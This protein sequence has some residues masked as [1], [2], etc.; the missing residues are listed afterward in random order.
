MKLIKLSLV[1]LLIGATGVGDAWA[2]RGHGHRHGHGV[3]FGFVAGPFWGPWYGSRHYP[4]V[5]IE[6]VSPPV[7]IER[8]SD[9]GSA[10][11][12]YYCA[13]AKGYYPYVKQCPGGWQQVAPRPEDQ[14]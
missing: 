11:F 14:P 8:S 10:N 7:Y 12:W 1:L 9:S 2:G 13:A 6:H 4:P 3:H 5:I